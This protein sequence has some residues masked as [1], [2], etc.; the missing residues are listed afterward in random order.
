LA[1]VRRGHLPRQEEWNRRAHDDDHED[2]S[3]SPSPESRTTCAEGIANQH[4]A[5]SERGAEGTAKKIESAETVERRQR[6]R[7]VRES[8]CDGGETSQRD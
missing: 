6:A 2:A 5:G 8:D 4:E 1:T 7:L 3:A